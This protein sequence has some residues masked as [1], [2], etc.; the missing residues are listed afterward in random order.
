MDGIV[1]RLLAAVVITFLCGCATTLPNAG[2]LTYK[3]RAV[4]RTEGGLRV[5]ASVL[6]AEE[7]EAVYG[8]PLAKRRFSPYGSRCRTTT[9]SAIS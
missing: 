4:T 1:N 3:S 6:S 9:R 8:V 7:S 2:G 5:S